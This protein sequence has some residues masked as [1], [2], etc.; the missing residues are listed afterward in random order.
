MFATLK[1]ISTDKEGRIIK[2]DQVQTSQGQ[3]GSPIILKLNTMFIK[4]LEFILAVIGDI[5]LE[6]LL[7]P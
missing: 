7:N 1:E 6:H 2:Y 4:L 3:S 5:I